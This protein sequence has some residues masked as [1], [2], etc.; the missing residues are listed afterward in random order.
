M[1]KTILITGTSSGWARHGGDPSPRRPHGVRID[2]R[3][4]KAKPR[5]R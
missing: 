2:A 5:G 1:S 4:K 3:V